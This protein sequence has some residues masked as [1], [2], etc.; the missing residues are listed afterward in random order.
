MKKLL[1]VGIILLFIGMNIPSTG[2]M[3]EKSYIN[4]LYT[5][6]DPIYINGN[7]D[8]TSENG[9]TGGSGT[10][11][12]PY[13]IEDWEINAS[14]KDGMIIWNTSV[15]FEINNCCIHSGGMKKDGIE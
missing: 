8:F 6:H 15:F 4:I 3:V 1:I 5:P 10:Y 7:Y 14:S 12:Y 9:V 13:I 11:N 2:T